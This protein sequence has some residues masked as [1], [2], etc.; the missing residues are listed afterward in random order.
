MTIRPQGSKGAAV[1]IGAILL[2]ALS[3]RAQIPSIDYQDCLDRS[4]LSYRECTERYFDA[5]LERCRSAAGDCLPWLP[6]GN[7]GGLGF[8]RT[9]PDGECRARGDA[10]AKFLE[11]TLS[12]NTERSEARDAYEAPYGQ[13]MEYELELRLASGAALTTENQSLVLAQLH[14]LNGHSPVFALRWKGGDQLAVTLRHR[15]DVN[16]PDENGAAVEVARIEFVRGAWHRFR[17]EILTG[18]RGYLRVF[19]NH[20]QV[21]DYRGPVGYAE[22]ASYF[23]FG[24]Y[25]WTRSGRRTHRLDVRDYSRRRASQSD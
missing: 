1:L 21:A 6:A 17:I 18:E 13:A 3:A 11:F 15:T 25:D 10:G 14:A 23:K 19:Q 8:R 12:P 16:A 4:E 24:I 2:I 7:F 5:V 22:L 20:R 9:S